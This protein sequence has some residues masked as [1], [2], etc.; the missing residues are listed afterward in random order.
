MNAPKIGAVEQTNTKEI[1]QPDVDT[2]QPS[3]NGSSFS[4]RGVGHSWKSS[5]ASEQPSLF[6]SGGHM[7]GGK[8]ALICTF[9]NRQLEDQ[10]ALHGMGEDSIDENMVNR[11]LANANP[12]FNYSQFKRGALRG[13]GDFE[14]Q[15]K[16]T[17]QNGDFALRVDPYADVVDQTSQALGAIYDGISK[18][19]LK[20]D[21]DAST[22]QPMR[23][24]PFKSARPSG[25]DD[26]EKSFMGG[27]GTEDMQTE[28][29]AEDAGGEGYYYNDTFDEGNDAQHA[30]NR[31][32]DTGLRRINIRSSQSKQLE[33][34]AQKD[35]IMQAYN[36]SQNAYAENLK[37]HF[38]SAFMGQE[39]REE[40]LERLRNPLSKYTAGQIGVN[41]LSRDRAK[42]YKS[43]HHNAP[44]KLNGMLV[45]V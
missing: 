35:S 42:A 18:S 22:S 38:H 37:Q 27:Q 4:I 32:E 9:R 7:D 12:E 5:T 19:G 16:V 39:E 21:V 15:V 24:N 3:S 44:T 41:D 13:D 29:E 28:Q 14:G 10:L 34:V 31:N 20:N 40:T 45:G 11:K 17:T 1:A 36:E 23:S 2:T 43:K 33:R 6:G 8:T 26:E 25:N 30:V